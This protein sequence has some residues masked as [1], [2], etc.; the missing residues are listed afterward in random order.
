M[1]L[2]SLR[3]SE[4]WLNCHCQCCKGRKSPR[5]KSWYCHKCD[6]RI[7]VAVRKSVKVWHRK[8]AANPGGTP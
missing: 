7:A 2:K 1:C 6:R 8:S 5:R 3:E 4:S